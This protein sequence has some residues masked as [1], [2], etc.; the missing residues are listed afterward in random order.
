L[1]FAFPLAFASLPLPLPELDEAAEAA[2]AASQCRTQARAPYI[3]AYTVALEI[4][5]LS[6]FKKWRSHLLSLPLAIAEIATAE[7]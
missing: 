1:A 4:L 5:T 3:I 2:A 7:L 6:S